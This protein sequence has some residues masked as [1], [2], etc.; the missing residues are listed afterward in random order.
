MGRS[1]K[2]G[3]CGS[4]KRHVKKIVG[5]VSQEGLRTLENICECVTNAGAVFLIGI[6]TIFEYVH[7]KVAFSFSPPPHAKF[8]FL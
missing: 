1:T 7:H 4:R 8:S 5:T 3:L 6:Y 2:V